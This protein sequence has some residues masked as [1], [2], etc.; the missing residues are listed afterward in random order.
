[1]GLRRKAIQIMIVQTDIEEPVIQ[2][3]NNVM[4]ICFEGDLANSQAF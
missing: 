2:N 4:K 3:I 1:M